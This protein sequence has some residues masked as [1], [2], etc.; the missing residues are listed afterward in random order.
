MV[1][2]PSKLLNEVRKSSFNSDK[3]KLDDH[4]IWFNN[5]LNDN[6]VQFYVLEF[7]D[8]LIGQLR[9]DF[10]EKYP[11]ISISLNKKYRNLGLSKILLSKGLKLIDGKVV[12]YIKNDNIR[13]ISF[14]KSMGFKKDS[15]VIIKDCPAL[16]FIKE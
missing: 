16:K 1:K 12:A 15:E 8:D 9:L 10:D 13:S 2:V 3:I 6:T 14:F 4:K 7:Q 5:V 11:V